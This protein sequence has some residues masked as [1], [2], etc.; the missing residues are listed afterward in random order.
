MILDLIFFVFIALICEHQLGFYS[1]VLQGEYVAQ[2]QNLNI[3]L[4]SLSGAV[5]AFLVFNF[6]LLFFNNLPSADDIDTRGEG[7]DVVL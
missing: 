6:Y 1:Q 3:I 5:L 7:I 2:M 4:W